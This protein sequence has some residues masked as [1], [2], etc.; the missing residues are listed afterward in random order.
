MIIDALCTSDR[1]NLFKCA[2]VDYPQRIDYL[3]YHVV[4][5]CI[6]VLYLGQELGYDRLRLDELGIAAFLHDIGIV[7]HLMLINKSGVLT[8][9]EYLAVKKHPQDALEIIGKIGIKLNQN[10]LDAISQEHERLDGSGYPSGLS[11]GQISEYAQLIGLLDVYESLMH[12]RPHRDKY[13]AFDAMKSM[14]NMKNGFDRRLLK[15]VIDKVGLF[16]VGSL[17]RLNTKETAI[18]AESKQR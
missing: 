7:R 6:L 11:A 5:V 15:M 1:N 18:V 13:S 16:P 9:N 2:I 17:V 3:Y 8:R 10:I 12:V 4:N 14:I